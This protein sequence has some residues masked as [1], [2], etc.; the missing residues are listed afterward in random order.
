MTEAVL[1]VMEAGEMPVMT[2][3]LVTA[4]TV[5]NRQTNTA[6]AIKNREGDMAPCW[7][8]SKQMAQRRKLTTMS[9]TS[10]T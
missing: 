5:T 8:K 6:A 4:K 1:T 10:L 3:V 2:V 7:W 9:A